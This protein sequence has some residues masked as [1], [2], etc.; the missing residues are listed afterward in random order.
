MDHHCLMPSRASPVWPP[1]QKTSA[2]GYFRAPQD[3]PHFPVL[4]VPGI[5]CSIMGFSL[6]PGSGSQCLQQPSLVSIWLPLHASVPTVTFYNSDPQSRSYQGP[7]SVGQAYLPHGLRLEGM[8]GQTTIKQRKV[9]R[10]PCLAS[11]PHAR[12]RWCPRSVMRDP[13]AVPHRLS[14]WVRSSW[15]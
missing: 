3:Y 8:E 4:S 6:S 1:L 7:A 11:T 12:L 10:R 13:R 9:R 15:R 14:R 2:R 5:P